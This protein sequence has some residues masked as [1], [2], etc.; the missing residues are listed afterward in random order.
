MI[1]QLRDR[2]MLPSQYDVGRKSVIATFCLCERRESDSRE[3]SKRV[4]L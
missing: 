3:I 1:A 4:D 2:S